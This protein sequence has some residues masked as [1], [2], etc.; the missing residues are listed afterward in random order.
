MNS[1]HIEQ[2]KHLCQFDSVTSFN[3]AIDHHLSLHKERFTK[4][5]R[6]ALDRLIRYSVKHHGICNARVSKLVQATHQKERGISRASFDRMLK[7]AKELKILTIHHTIRA[8][9]GFSHCVYVF[10]AFDK[11]SEEKLINRPQAKKTDPARITPSNSASKAL[12]KDKA[13]NQNRII[14]TKDEQTTNLSSNLFDIPS[15]F[16]TLL[17]AF[18]DL[19]ENFTYKL[20]GTAKSVYNRMQLDNPIEDYLLTIIQA[21][22]E[23]IKKYKHGRIDK[24]LR[25]YYYGTLAAMLVVIKRQEVHQREKWSFWLQA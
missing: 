10:E 16:V 20:W 19:E 25:H 11:P 21:F 5:E 7:K 4:A 1:G 2:Y 8:K 14:R 12:F 9:G 3:Q 17:Q 23:T 18:E 13:K 22:K 24:G 15:R 6:V